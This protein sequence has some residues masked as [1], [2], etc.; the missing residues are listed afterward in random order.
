MLA[1]AMSVFRSV[2]T[3]NFPDIDPLLDLKERFF[4]FI[5]SE[6]P[7]TVPFKS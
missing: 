1:V 3:S 2:A 6:F 7:V 4:P 5:K